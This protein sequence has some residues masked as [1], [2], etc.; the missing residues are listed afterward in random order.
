MKNA[1]ESINSCIYQTEDKISELEARNFE[2][3]KSK[4][5]KEKKQTKPT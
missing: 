2:I 5:N 3:P 1:I 4:E